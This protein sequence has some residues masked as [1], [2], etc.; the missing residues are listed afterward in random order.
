MS[1]PAY[2]LRDVA[3]AYHARAPVLQGIDLDLEAGGI[4]A[5]SGANGAGKST[6]LNLLAL[7]LPPAAGRMEFFGAPL[8]GQA[9]PGSRLR[10][11]VGLLPQDPYL[12]D[13]PALDNIIAGLRFRGVQRRAA[14]ARAHALLTELDLRFLAQRPVSA[15]SGGE[16]QKL[17]IVRL[18]VLQPRVLLL[19][20]PFGALDGAARRDLEALL[21]RACRLHE[22]LL[23]FSSH[24]LLHARLLA[25]RVLQVQGG[26]VL[27]AREVNLYRGR[28]DTAAGVFDTGRLRIC[29]LPGG[30]PGEHAYVDPDVVVLATTRPDTSMNNTFQGRISAI[31]VPPG[32]SGVLVTVDCGEVV[33]A[34][35]TRSTAQALDLKVG[36]LV[37]TGFKAAAVRVL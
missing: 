17:A 26:T 24:D 22:R 37:W 27:P 19:D 1:A 30:T 2:R 16:R 25:D 35:V 33:R 7:E 8:A 36:D 12:L 21:R 15:L 23:V 32:E 4:V 28:A 6:L 29:T 20:E 34:H 5:L 14:E 3:V 11:Q 31:G 9:G 18:L 13:R 10:M